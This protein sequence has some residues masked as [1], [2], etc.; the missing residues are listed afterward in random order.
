MLSSDARVAL[1]P[2]A[3]FRELI[4]ERPPGFWRALARPA[5]VLLVIAVGLPIAAVH[6]V[7]VKLVLT[8][9]AA[10]SFIVVVQ[11]AIA[12][13]MI[14]SAPSRR[15]SF[16][17]AFDLWFAGHV[18]YSLWIL[19]IPLVTAVPAGTPHELMGLAFIV[20][21]VWTTVIVAA[22]CRVV[23]GLAAADASRRAALH[24]ATVVIVV[25]ALATWAAGGPAA[26]VSYVAHR[27]GRI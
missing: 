24:L 1:R 17:H 8:T 20:P 7:T 9:A 12:A 13:A 15:V 19:A 23:L 25:A 26:I 2:D 18:P 27:L 22:F 6:Q 10:W 3:T 14:A 16:L 21:L 4:A 5:L 11:M